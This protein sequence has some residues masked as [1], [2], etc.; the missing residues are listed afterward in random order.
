LNALGF[1]FHL[2]LFAALS[3]EI[4]LS[5]KAV[6]DCRE[7]VAFGYAFIICRAGRGG[8]HFDSVKAAIVWLLV[9][10][11]LLKM[12]SKSPGKK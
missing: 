2:P 4:C 5:G 1:C 8:I 3:A 10:E 7:A 12:G 11:Q 9:S 6:R